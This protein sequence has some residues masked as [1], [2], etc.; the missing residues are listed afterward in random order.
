MDASVFWIY[1]YDSELNRL[2]LVGG[3]EN[4]VENI[5]HSYE[6]TEKNRPTVRC[7][8][9]QKTFVFTD[10]Q[11]EYPSIFGGNPPQP[12]KGVSYNS[13]IFLPLVIK[14]SQDKDDKKVG[15]ITVQSVHKKAY[16]DYHVNIL[17][18]IGGYA[19]IALDNASAYKKIEDQKSTIE[20]QKVKVEVALG[21]EKEISDHKDSLMH[22]VSHQYKTP[23]SIIRS[24]AQILRDKWSELSK[25]D[26][27]DQTNRILKN[28]KRMFMLI[29]DLLL[30]SKRYNP[31]SYNLA[32][33]FRTFVD[34]IKIHEGRNHEIIF[35][36]S[37][38]CEKIKIDK[39]LMK[40]ILHNLI[41][42]AINYSPKRSRILIDLDC[43]K[44]NAV[45]KIT[46]RGIGIP[47]DYFKMKFERFH[48]GSNVGDITGT[49]LGLSIVKRYVDLHKG[50]IEIVSQLNA[51]T[52]VTVTIPR[53]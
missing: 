48:R 37:G 4:G 9:E 6:L 44:E 26:I 36:N 41:V 1:W 51:G 46:D 49:G 2:V 21:K 32:D 16:S 23:I 18:G 27:E 31:D 14:G 43:N 22:T 40:I 30:Y 13:H 35:I 3:K 52:T 19:A 11:I 39:D 28:I 12:K 8:L 50:S 47:E 33:I 38:K 45:I 10:Y 17:K 42:N 24:S 20:E 34:E 29:D 7:F 5:S 15:V 25:E 53:G